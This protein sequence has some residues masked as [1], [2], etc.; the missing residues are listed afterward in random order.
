[1]SYGGSTF[2]VEA[3][4]TQTQAAK[5]PLSPGDATWV[6]ISHVHVLTHPG[7]RFLLLSDGSAHAQA[8]LGIGGQI[9]RL[10]HARV[11][12]LGYGMGDA[13]LNQHLQASKERLGSGL[14]ALDVHSTLED[15]EEAVAAEVERQPQDLVVLGSDGSP[16]SI[17]LAEKI[18]Q[19]G[20]HHLLVTST[21]QG[22]PQQALIC[23]ARGE[24][25]K[26]DVLFAGRLLRHLGAHATLLTILPEVG[27]VPA[28]LERTQHYLDSGVRALDVLGV[29]ADTAV[30]V[31]PVF[32]G[33]V[34]KLNEGGYDL[35]VL[36][37]PLPDVDGKTMFN[38]LIGQVLRTMTGRSVL[39]VRSS[40]QMG[41]SP[42]LMP[43]SGRPARSL[44]TALPAKRRVA[45][46]PV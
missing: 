36:G 11:T 1:V 10:A 4:R 25:G 5:L 31:G 38:G 7:L 22:V 35:L 34:R 13:A 16:R 12:L 41:A 39:I 17:A 44:S 45:N 28:A 8:A 14:A 3:T 20:D 40:R 42:L 32:D 26:E 33:I 30:H 18:W 27:P 19:T 15:P 37:A 23:V 24:P 2:V 46:S 21:S 29:P 6:G 43:V 9:A